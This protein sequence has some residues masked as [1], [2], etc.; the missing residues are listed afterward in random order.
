METVCYTET[1]LSTYESTR[2]HNTDNIVIL[3]ALRLSNFIRS[4]TL[5]PVHFK[6]VGL[7][8]FSSLN[9]FVSASINAVFISRTIRKVARFQ[10]LTAA[11]MKFVDIALCSHVEVYRRFRGAYCLHRQDDE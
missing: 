5:V 1:L 11:S 9:K 8:T 10:V 6:S 2:R 7:Y 3:T 4:S